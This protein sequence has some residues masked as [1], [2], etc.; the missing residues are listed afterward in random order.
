MRISQ[1][2]RGAMAALLMVASLLLPS[3]AS[4]VPMA[5][6]EAA[7]E[8]AVR[9]LNLM[10]FRIKRFHNDARNSLANTMELPYFAGTAIS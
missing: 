8:Q 10:V 4:S 9:H 6:V 1:R 7:R 2:K 5:T 3:I